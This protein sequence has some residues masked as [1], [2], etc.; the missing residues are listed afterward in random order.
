MIRVTVVRKNGNIIGYFAKGHAEYAELGSDIVCAAASTVMQN[1][2]AGMQEVLHLSP[3]Y[4]FDD[5][6]Y[7]TVNLEG[8]DFQKKEKEVSSLLET[9]VVMIRELERNYPK[10]IKLV[11]KEEK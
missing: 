11:E 3:Q 8:M 6:G 10:N 4:G 1:P 9:M 7:I 2:L 5:D